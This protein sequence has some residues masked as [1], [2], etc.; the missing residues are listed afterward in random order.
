[1]DKNE[2]E[3]KQPG[4]ELDALVLKALNGLSLTVMDCRMVDGEY[5]P[6][7]GYPAGH[8]S[9][10]PYSTELESTILAL[11]EWA[12]KWDCEW[13]LKRLTSRGLAKYSCSI[14]NGQG[15]YHFSSDLSTTMVAE[16]LPLAACRALLLSARIQPEGGPHR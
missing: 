9:P 8:I 14:R 3:F 4:R 5:Q 12:E 6:R 11:D 16:T 15:L 1:M 2:I 13:S 10:Y 7:L